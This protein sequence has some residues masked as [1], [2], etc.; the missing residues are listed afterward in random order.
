MLRILG[1]IVAGAELTSEQTTLLPLKML[2][3]NESNKESVLLRKPLQYEEL[4]D[5]LFNNSYNLTNFTRDDW[6]APTFMTI[7]VPTVFSIIFMIGSVG[8]IFTIYIVTRRIKLKS[9]TSVY[10]LSL[11]CADLLFVITS[12]LFAAEFLLA[13][14]YKFGEIGCRLIDAM[15]IMT[16]LASVFTLTVM[17]ID[18]FFAVVFPLKTM[19]Y[20]LRAVASYVNIAVWT[21]SFVFSLPMI[22]MAKEGPSRLADGSVIRSCQ[23]LMD[24]EFDKL[25]KTT[26]FIFAFPIPFVIIL[27]CYITIAVTL[28]SKGGL[29]AIAETNKSRQSKQR[30]AKMVLIIV[31][32]FFVCWLPFW[33]MMML[34]VYG[35]I[36]WSQSLFYVNFTLVCIS[37]S[38]SCANPLLYT[39]LSHNVRRKLRMRGTSTMGSER[40]SEANTTHL[41]RKSIRG[42]SY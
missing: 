2:E 18:R 32:V 40:I 8:N 39:L 6:E 13:P 14:E 27:V 19:A 7:L 3:G 16:M 20:R 30:V 26:I 21:L 15:D 33:T 35:M 4:L 11:A 9:T 25:Y 12:P 34:A 29:T 36:E 24:D 37:Y 10:I 1:F 23:S 5:S 42:K 41:H 22:I 17:S 31:I 38:N 28:L